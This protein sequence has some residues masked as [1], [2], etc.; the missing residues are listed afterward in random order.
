MI[1]EASKGLLTDRDILV[2]PLDVT[3]TSTHATAFDRAVRHFGH[4][5]VLY[6]NAGRSQRAFWEDIDLEV[7]KE[8][9]NLNVF[10]VVNLSRIAVAHFKKRGSGIVA[11]NSSIAGVLG[12]P[13]SGTY[14]GSK[15]AIHVRSLHL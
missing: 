8:M 1:L 9:F 4:V 5:D 7:D 10:G 2:I 15:H 11:V 3:D 13:F 6:N 12:V 14:T